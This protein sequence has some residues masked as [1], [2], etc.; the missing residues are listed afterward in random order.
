MTAV[1]SMNAD[2]KNNVKEKILDNNLTKIQ[3]WASEGASSI[4]K[5][6]GMSEGT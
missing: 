3:Q 6:R 4:V 5:T 2:L 1:D